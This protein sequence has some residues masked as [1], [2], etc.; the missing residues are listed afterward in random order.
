MMMPFLIAYCTVFTPLFFCRGSV[1]PVDVKAFTADTKRILVEKTS[2][3]NTISDFSRAV[4]EICEADQCLAVDKD[5][6]GRKT[7]Q[8]LEIKN[9][10]FILVDDDHKKIKE[11]E[12]DDI[13]KEALTELKEGQSFDGCVR[14]I[15]E[16]LE[17]SQSNKK[18]RKMD[19]HVDGLKMKDSSAIYTKNM[20]SPNM[21]DL[22]DEASLRLSGSDSNFYRNKMSPEKFSESNGHKLASSESQASK[23]FKE[24]RKLEVRNA[25]DQQSAR[26]EAQD[27]L[28]IVGYQRHNKTSTSLYKQSE[29]SSQVCSSYLS[30][31]SIPHLLYEFAFF[32]LPV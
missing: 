7:D 14:R 5:V 9:N 27:Q 2:L 16:E 8:R 6:D 23:K 29:L 26:S 17:E 19:S 22:A 10:E 20:L 24:H 25:G 21:K 3:K 1:Q 30:L 31:D 4:K 32:T 12:D 11:D 18:H 13:L 15:F 28:S